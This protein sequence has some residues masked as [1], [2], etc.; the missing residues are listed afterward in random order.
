M[1]PQ[2]IFSQGFQEILL[3]L[4]ESY[5]VL[6]ACALGNDFNSGQMEAL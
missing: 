4:S 3:D 5:S 1:P 6:V 2:S